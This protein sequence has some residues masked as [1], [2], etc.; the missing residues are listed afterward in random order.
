MREGIERM[1]FHQTVLRSGT[2]AGA[3]KPA[4]ATG[5][6]PEWDLTHL[7]PGIESPEFKSDLE[8]G[9]VEAQ[10]L[11]AAI[12]ASSPISRPRPTV[13]RRWRPR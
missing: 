8:R 3:A 11:P 6:L 5:D 10:A 12:A 1:G 7:Y 9:L 2:K 4:K 13:A